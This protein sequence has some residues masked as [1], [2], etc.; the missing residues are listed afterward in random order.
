MSRCL[1]SRGLTVSLLLV[2]LSACSVGPRY[3]PP[4]ATVP[5]NWNQFAK[6]APSM[7]LQ[8]W[9]RHFH[10]PLLNEL[11][12]QQALH[13]LTLQT[14]QARIRAARADYAIAHAQLFPKVNANLLPPD[15]TGVGLTQ[16][17]AL[18]ATLEPDLFGK[19][20]E[21]R[22][23]AAA[24]V[25]AE[26]AEH[27]FALLNLQAE[28]A[29]SYLELREAQAKVKIFNHNLQGNHEVLSL[30]RSKQ[31]SG[32]SRYL[33]IT[34][35]EVLIATQLAEA[36]QNTAVILALIHKLELLTGNPPGG[37][38][39]KLRSPKTVPQIHEAINLGI[40]ADLLRRRPDIIAAERRVAA[41]HANIRIAMANLFPQVSIGW[42]FAWQTETIASNIL[43]MHNSTSS[44]LGTF[45]APLLNL[46]LHRTVDFRKREK[47][48]AVIQYELAVLRALH[49]VETQYN[50]C[51]HY[52]RS[53]RFLKQATEKK[54]L[55]L[56]LAK[57]VYQKG[58]SGFDTV[59]HAEED[60]SRLEIAYLHQTVLY[61]IARINLYTALGGDIP[62]M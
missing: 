33:D 49:N 12:E 46:T 42:L 40:P 44:L 39:N 20:R 7:N 23:R 13:N 53:N 34:Q 1:L 37:L 47:E 15:G 59:L 5:E 24:T 10:D 31:Q 51:Q 58:A 57:D 3:V 17:L 25:E 52:Q 26:Q 32:L 22:H 29:S 28:I 21:N 38:L 19:Q 36:E 45:N 27:D 8:T 11:I 18:S 43:A 61:Q 35:Q 4:V 60:L 2:L 14:A 54:Q 48:L 16:V 50:Y 9:W 6:S 56:N 55:V 30:L 41:A 62:L